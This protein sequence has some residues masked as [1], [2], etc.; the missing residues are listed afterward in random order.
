MLSRQQTSSH[1]I[2][3]TLLN[4]QAHIRYRRPQ[5]AGECSLKFNLNSAPRSQQTHFKAQEP[6]GAGGHHTGQ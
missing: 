4:A 3:K 5:V 2:L 6:H 1:I